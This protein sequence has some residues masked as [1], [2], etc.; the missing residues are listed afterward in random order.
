MA[1]NARMLPFFARGGMA[2]SLCLG[3]TICP[4]LVLNPDRI[5]F[6][7]LVFCHH[8]KFENGELLPEVYF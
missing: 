4:F 3:V 8:L 1:S 6:Q 5:P 2:Q 7:N